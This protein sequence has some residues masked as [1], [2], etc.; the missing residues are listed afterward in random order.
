MAGSAGAVSAACHQGD[1][2]QIPYGRTWDHR[3]GMAAGCDLGRTGKRQF[4]AVSYDQD[5]H[6]LL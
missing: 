4:Y 3:G 1:R 2:I 5:V 6:S